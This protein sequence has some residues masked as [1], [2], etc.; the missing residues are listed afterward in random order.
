MKTTNRLFFGT[1]FLSLLMFTSCSDTSFD[2][3]N[4]N[5][6][7]SLY[8]SDKIP[9]LFGDES[10]DIQF[11][12]YYVGA[13]T[14]LFDHQT[15]SILDVPPVYP[16]IIT[17]DEPIWFVNG[18]GTD[19]AKQYKNMVE[20][21][22]FTGRPV[23]G[24]HNGTKEGIADVIEIILPTNET[25]EAAIEKSVL[26]IIDTEEKVLLLGHSQG[27]YHLARSLRS[28]ENQLSNNQL[29]QL[30]VETIGGAGMWFPRGPQYIHYANQ[31]DN[32]PKFHG[33]LTPGALPG[34]RSV[35]FTFDDEWYDI[36]PEID[37]PFIR[38]HAQIVYLRNRLTFAEAR[39]YA[40]LFGHKKINLDNL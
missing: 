34:N 2:E 39:T 5:T 37:T 11:D 20:I 9:L 38:V 35:I 40:P 14:L 4:L 13:D 36:P 26:E 7:E 28:L 33:V 17:N 6:T 32:V 21:A 29:G 30:M 22:E 18:A 31:G 25:V 27:A 10:E 16:D 15:T 12:G 8:E 23:V 1:T 24:I 19:V 3:A